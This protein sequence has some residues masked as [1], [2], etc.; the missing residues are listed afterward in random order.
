MPTLNQ[1]LKDQNFIE[2]DR[3]L[4]EFNI[5]NALGI[6]H[7]EVRHGKFLAHLLDPKETHGLGSEFLENFLLWLDDACKL[8][9]DL[10]GLDVSETTIE[11]EWSP[12]NNNNGRL[13]ILAKIPLKN[14]S[15]NHIYIAIELKIR[16]TQHDNQLE[17]YYKALCEEN[18]EPAAAILLT[19]T[20][21]TP[22]NNNW[23]NA[24]IMDV[25]IPA[26]KTTL[27]K[28]ASNCSQKLIAVLKDYKSIVTSLSSS[29]DDEI[30]RHS[31]FC[32]PLLAY[33]EAIEKE[34][35]KTYLRSNHKKTLAHLAKFIEASNDVRGQ[36]S[37]KF[38]TKEAPFNEIEY[39]PIFSSRAH[40]IFYPGN[41]YPYI[42]DAG[43][44][45]Q[46]NN[47]FLNIDAW[48]IYFEFRITEANG[49]NNELN[50]TCNLILGPLNPALHQDR[51]NLANEIRKIVQDGWI[52]GQ[53][54]GQ[55]RTAIASKNKKINNAEGLKN[56][57]MESKSLSDGIE[58]SLSGDGNFPWIINPQ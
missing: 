6:D 58:K 8:D 12:Q 3:K 9:V 45:G 39:T 4:N 22:E 43:M 36:L 56:L 29:A 5:F 21:E 16:A 18:K 10:I 35:N 50:A 40:W 23:R 54:H 26:L 20:E 13:D 27:N 24:K 47:A 44:E 38:A 51:E 15:T 48:P 33:K 41:N 52:A 30:Y 32:L 11:T 1:L 37:R 31:A 55:I 2:L 46:Y 17:R 57:I 25:V 14:N 53:R 42:R 7:Y 19:L 34:E 28:V 49:N